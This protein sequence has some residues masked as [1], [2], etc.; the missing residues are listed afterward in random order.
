MTIINTLLELVM[1]TVAAL[2]KL[3]GLKYLSKQILQLI[4]I[5]SCCCIL[6]CVVSLNWRLKLC[7]HFQNPLSIGYL[8]NQLML[9]HPFFDNCIIP[10]C[11]AELICDFTFKIIL[12]CGMTSRMMN[13]F[14][15]W[16]IKKK[17]K[18]FVGAT[19]FLLLNPILSWF[20]AR[21]FTPKLAPGGIIGRLK[22][23]QTFGM[24]NR[25]TRNINCNLLSFD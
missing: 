11:N 1:I 19:H 18:S 24:W 9:L 20:A 10:G 2:R 17:S 23:D 8:I 21:A 15:I 6:Y 16:K 7:L 25:E 14:H 13:L 4:S 3:F 12:N 22:M 5:V